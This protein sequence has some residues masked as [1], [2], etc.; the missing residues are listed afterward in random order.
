MSWWDVEGDL[1]GDLGAG[2][3]IFGPGVEITDLARICTGIYAN[4]VSFLVTY[5]VLSSRGL[6]T[7]QRRYNI[8]T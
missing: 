1:S 6:Q 3:G 8:E 4:G 7:G 2:E 5:V